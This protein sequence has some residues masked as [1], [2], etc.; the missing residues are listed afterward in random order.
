MREAK[1]MKERRKSSEE[2]DGEARQGGDNNRDER[3]GDVKENNN[4]GSRL[5]DCRVKGEERRARR[6]NKT[7]KRE[8]K[9]EQRLKKK[10][11]ETQSYK[12]K[13]KN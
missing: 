5:R 10:S 3:K 8:D 6:A 11:A 7:R 2:G 1:D 4:S 13:L 9:R 12:W